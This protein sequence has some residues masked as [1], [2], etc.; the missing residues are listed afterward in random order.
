MSILLEEQLDTKRN[1]NLYGSWIYDGS[2]VY[3]SLRR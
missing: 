1:Y 2:G 3:G